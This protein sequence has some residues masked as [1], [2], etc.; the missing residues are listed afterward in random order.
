MSTD[1]FNLP[2]LYRIKNDKGQYC[3]GGSPP[4]FVR[5]HGKLF[6]G[7]QA[8]R[9]YLRLLEESSDL[10]IEEFQASCKATSHIKHAAQHLSKNSET[11][12]P[13][14]PLP[15]M[16]NMG[17]GIVRIVDDD[18]GIAYHVFADKI[19]YVTEHSGS[20]CSIHFAKESISVKATT[21]QALLVIKDSQR[22]PF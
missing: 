15:P 13:V 20:Y 16:M 10:Y 18:S 9:V 5:G 22:L 21:K 3:A 17:D 6:V 1:P 11:V 19:T 14:P 12:E 2:T 4:R 7:A 8:L